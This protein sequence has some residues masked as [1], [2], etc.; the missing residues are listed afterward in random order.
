MIKTKIDFYKKEATNNLNLLND[1]QSGAL[2]GEGSSFF[3]LCKEKNKNTLAEVIGTK[4]FYRPG[5]NNAIQENISN[6]LNTH[7]LTTKDI[8]LVIL[9]YNGDAEFDKIY[10]G[11]EDN[12]FA[13]NTTAF[14]K[15]LSGEYDTSSAFAMWLAAGIIN[16]NKVPDAIL[17]KGK[18]KGEIKKVLIYNQFRNINHSLILLRKP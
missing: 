1:N 9:G 17:K 16:K 5:S 18:A 10:S 14:Y 12:L 3:V 4:M 7:S 6:F 15:H 11:L 13:K 8:D 2:A